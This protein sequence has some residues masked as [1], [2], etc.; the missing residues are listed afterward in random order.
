MNTKAVQQEYSE[1]AHIGWTTGSHTGSPVPVW[2][3]GAGSQLFAGRMD[4]TD[5]PR[6]ICQAMGVD[7]E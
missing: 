5:I 4:N 1:R 6:K 2:A 3:V 7:F